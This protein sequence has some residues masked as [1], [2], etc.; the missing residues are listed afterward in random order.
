LSRALNL[1]DSIQPALG[2]VSLHA[3][4][5]TLPEAIARPRYALDQILTGTAGP[6]ALPNDGVAMPPSALQRVPE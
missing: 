1:P 4:C 6:E 3:A 2:E 5:A